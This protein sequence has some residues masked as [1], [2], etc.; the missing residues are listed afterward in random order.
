MVPSPE[1]GETSAMTRPVL[2]PTVPIHD[3]PVVRTEK[4]SCVGKTSM[5]VFSGGV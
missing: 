2:A 5:Y 4:A 3:E 1:R